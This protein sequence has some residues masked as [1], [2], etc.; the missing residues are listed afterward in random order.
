M[1]TTTAEDVRDLL[2]EA[3]GRPWAI[4][5]PCSQEMPEPDEE[6]FRLTARGAV[7]LGLEMDP[8]RRGPIA[9][10]SDELQLWVRFR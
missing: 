5:E 6:R 2:E 10:Y 1:T 3:S 8:E 7:A 9:A 4:A